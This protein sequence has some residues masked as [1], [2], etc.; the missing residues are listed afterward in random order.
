MKIDAQDITGA[1]FMINLSGLPER[2]FQ[3]EFD[4]LQV[5]FLNLRSFNR[6]WCNRKKSNCLEFLFM[7]DVAE[8]FK[9]QV[10]W[11]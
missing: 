3:H 10:L 4:H 2:V 9:T 8:S 1:R 6:C 5:L 11:C 7:E